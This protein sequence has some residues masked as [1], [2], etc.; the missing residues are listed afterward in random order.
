MLRGK[1]IVLRR[2]RDKDWEHIDKWAEEADA[3]FG[4]YQ[5][6]QVGLLAELKEG[7]QKN[8]LLGRDSGFMIVELIEGELPIGIVRYVPLGLPDEDLPVPEVGF[9]IA[10]EG[11]RGKGYAKEAAALLIRYLYDTSPTERIMAVTSSDNVPSQRVLDVGGQ[12]TRAIA[13]RPD[14]A[15]LKFEMAVAAL[16]CAIIGNA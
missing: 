6:F 4:P 9:A 1:R 10:E 14:G 16:G 11:S 15:I 12:D 5:R 3:L 2:V 7:Y 13:L 8:G